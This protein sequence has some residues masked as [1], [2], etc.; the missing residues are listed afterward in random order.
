M[1]RLFW[2]KMNLG[3]CRPTNLLHWIA[4][5]GVFSMHSRR[6]SQSVKI[7]F[8]IGDL[9]GGVIIFASL[10]DSVQAC[11]NGGERGSVLFTLGEGEGLSGVRS[12]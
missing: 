12:F 11:L 7:L 5:L 4:P 6:P 1:M 2:L 10:R 3:F 8:L 9:A